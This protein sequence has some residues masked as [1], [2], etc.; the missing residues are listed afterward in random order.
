MQK[1]YTPLGRAIC[2]TSLGIVSCSVSFWV[3]PKYNHETYSKQ[4]CGHNAFF[5]PLARVAKIPP[6]II[7]LL[8]GFYFLNIQAINAISA[9]KRINLK[10]LPKY[11]VIPARVPASFN[12]FVSS[13]LPNQYQI[14]TLFPSLIII[15]LNGSNQQIQDICFH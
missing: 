8:I 7:I 2:T 14:P 9:I 10:T 4:T 11:C 15:F 13:T 1:R 6:T 12:R 3:E 5:L